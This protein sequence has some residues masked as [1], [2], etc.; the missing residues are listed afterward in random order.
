MREKAD[1]RLRALERVAALHHHRQQ[2]ITVR[3]WAR[4]RNTG[5]TPKRWLRLPAAL[6]FQRL[7]ER[8][9]AAVDVMLAAFEG[10]NHDTDTAALAGA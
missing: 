7:A 5:E 8:R 9:G 2:A 1:R 10:G 4:W 6:A 3:E